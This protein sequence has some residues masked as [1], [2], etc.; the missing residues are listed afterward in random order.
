MGGMRMVLILF[1][2]L[3]LA[4]GSDMILYVAGNFT[5][6]GYNESIILAPGANMTGNDST[7]I[8][9]WSTDLYGE[10]GRPL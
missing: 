4:A 1:L 9:E 2:L 7:W 6:I 10:D 3:S 8:V 5:G